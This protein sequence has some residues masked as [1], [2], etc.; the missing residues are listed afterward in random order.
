M[1][2]IAY[3]FNSS[4]LFTVYM[5]LLLLS[6]TLGYY[7]FSVFET[8][9]FYNTYYESIYGADNNSNNEFNFEFFLLPTYFS[10]L[11]A[12]LGYLVNRDNIF[13]ISYQ[14]YLKK[15]ISLFKRNYSIDELYNT[16]IASPVLKFSYNI[17]YKLIDRGFLETLGPGGIWKKVTTFYLN[18]AFLHNGSIYNY[19]RLQIR[20]YIMI[21][22][23]V[24]I[25]FL[26]WQNIT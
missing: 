6:C 9:S 26:I 8:Q 4:K 7:F 21:C 15:Y 20:G 3:V 25:L 18:F 16:I 13:S 12:N 5:L 17:T 24:I 1:K 11:G 22:V 19:L 2:F 14:L 10:I 23:T